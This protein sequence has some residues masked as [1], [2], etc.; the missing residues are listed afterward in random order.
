MWID[1]L[2]VHP[3]YPLLAEL[4]TGTVAGEWKALE[5][6]RPL[7]G[8]YEADF[9]YRN[10]FG[11]RVVEDVKGVVTPLAHW[12]LRHFKAQYGFDVQ[13]VRMR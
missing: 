13:I 7:V 11:A 12:K 3:R 1:D 5:G 8:Y 6:E 9:S 4:T 10:K 2:Q